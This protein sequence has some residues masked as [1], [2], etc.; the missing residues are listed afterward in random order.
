PEVRERLSTELVSLSEKIQRGSRRKAEF[1]NEDAGDPA[2]SGKHS[3]RRYLDEPAR[4]PEASDF[5]KFNDELVILGKLLKRDPRRTDYYTRTLDRNP[6]LAK[7]MGTGDASD[8][9]A[10]EI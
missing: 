9:I 7:T 3:F 4:T 6:W 2:G 10:S 8:W 1:A 5:A